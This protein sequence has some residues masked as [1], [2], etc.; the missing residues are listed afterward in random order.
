MKLVIHSGA[1]SHFVPENMNLPRGGQSTKEVYL[2]DDTKLQA[3]YRTQLPIKQ[4]SDKAKE[5]DILPGLT[6]PLI[7]VNKLANKGYTT[8]FHP[9]EDGVTIYEPGTVKVTTTTDPIL[10]GCKL[11][12]ANLWTIEA[13]EPS[14][15]ELANTVYNLPSIAQTVRYLH[16]AA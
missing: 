4:L 3:T 12:G 11:K 1:T 8:I 16:A 13:N 15:T 14:A 2:P 7:S 9:G 6:T 5:A 10:Q